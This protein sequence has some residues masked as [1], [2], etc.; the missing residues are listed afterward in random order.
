VGTPACPDPRHSGLKFSIA[1][2]SGP[3]DF[4]VGGDSPFEQSALSAL[5][6]AAALAAAAER[7]LDVEVLFQSEFPH[8]AL[9]ISLPYPNPNHPADGDG[10]LPNPY[11]GRVNTMAVLDYGGGPCVETELAWAGSS[12]NAYF[13]CTDEENTVRWATLLAGAV[14]S[15]AKVTV[16]WLLPMRNADR[17]IVELTLT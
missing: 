1:T 9:G 14:T 12:G 16:E 10:T 6:M 13:V 5:A 4:Q 8:V 3:R 7:G 2:A 15:G 17:Q 11:S